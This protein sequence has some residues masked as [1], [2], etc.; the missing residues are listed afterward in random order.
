[1]NN[2]IKNFKDSRGILFSFQNKNFK[3]KRIFFIK[4]YINAIRG[5][6]AHKDTKQIII[7]INAKVII[8]TFV[9]SK[10]KKF[11]LRNSG[12]YIIC[13]KKTWVEI[14]FLKSGYLSVVCDKI[15]D[16]KDYIYDI[17]KLNK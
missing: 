1:M 4:G 3:I 8:K 9:N 10:K 14:K 17:N 6:H 2:S 11:I 16:K 13:N 7:N 5:K 15:Y 12:D